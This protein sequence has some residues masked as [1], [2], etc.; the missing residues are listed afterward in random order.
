[1]TT[2]S[3][4]EGRRDGQVQGRI[5]D[6]ATFP[7]AT[8]KL[9]DPI[10]FGKIPAAGETITTKA[11]INLTLHG[12]TK[13][14]D[15]N[16]QARLN[17]SNIEVV[18]NIPIVFADFGIPNPSTA[19]ITT[20]D[21]GLL[22]FALRELS[23]RVLEFFVFQEL[24]DQVPARIVLLRLL[25]RR[26][27]MRGEQRAAFDVDEVRSHDDEFAR[28]FEIE[29]LEGVHEFEVLLRDP[30]DGDVVNIDLIFLDEVEQQIER[31]LE[32]FEAD[33]VFVG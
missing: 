10:D 29:H 20:E 17:K 7:T 13:P 14:V 6:T 4:G 25:L 26:L 21:K 30:L 19:G 33:L 28:D 2:L 5:M 12:T 1:M 18:G 9:V 27:H 8:L 24:P 11:K 22:E 16:L 32:D 15:V 31:P 3:S 23:R